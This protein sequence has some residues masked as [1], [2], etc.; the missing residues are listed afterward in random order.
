MKDQQNDIKRGLEHLPQ[1]EADAQV[2]DHIEEALNDERNP[3]L[4]LWC[5]AR[6]IAAM[7]AIVLAVQ[8][9]LSDD[10]DLAD[11][12]KE[13][14]RLAAE[15]S[16]G[17][18]PNLP[19]QPR[20]PVSTTRTTTTVSPDKQDTQNT[21]LMFANADSSIVTLNV[22]GLSSGCMSANENY[23]SYKWSMGDGSSPSLSNRAFSYSTSNEHTVTLNNSNSSSFG[24]TAGTDYDQSNTIGYNDMD[25]KSTF[26]YTN[27]VIGNS[28]DE[29][30]ISGVNHTAGKTSN[31]V[32]PFGR[33]REKEKYQCIILDSVQFTNNSSF[34]SQDPQ[35][36]EP[37]NTENYFPLVEND[38]LSPLKEPLST[39]GIDVD[40]ASYA[41]MRTKINAQQIVPK[42]AVRIEEFVNYFDYDYPQPV[43]ND[44]FS[45]NLETANCPWNAKHQLVRIGLKGKD[46]DYQNLKHSNLVFLIDVSGSMDSENKLP[47]VKKSLKLL[48]DQMGKEDRIA[49]V[50]YAGAAGLALEST[51]CSEKEYIKKKIDQ[52]DAGGS[53]AGGQGITLAYKIAVENR[54]PEGNNRVIMCTDG[55]FNV[56]QSTDSD[57]KN[58]IIENR[59]RGIFITACGFG[60]GNYQDSKME[61]IADN[62][63]GNYFYIDT[64]REST[65]VFERDI[66]ATLFTIAKDVKIQV[67]FNP[68]HVKAYRLI[69]YENRKMPP[70]DFNDDSK[71]GGELGAGHTV[72]ALY[73][74][75]PAG[76]DEAIP[77][78][79]G[80]KYQ[81]PGMNTNTAFTN[82]LLTVK[83]RYKKPNG[84]VSWLIEKSIMAGSKPFEQSS[85]DFRFAA[86]T[87]LFAQQLRQSRHINE[88]NFDLALKIL[89]QSK[90]SDINGDRQELITL[91]NQAQKLY[92]I[93]TKRD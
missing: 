13:E 48:V 91:V 6:S 36:Y 35:L 73:E 81:Q 85:T 31:I 76:S 60:M 77:G 93:Y 50:T 74:I 23:P 53:T 21:E 65:K 8:F 49:I 61:T 14:L 71:D 70:Q 27:G 10:Q 51:K 25:A 66:R 17:I 59:N 18:T 34:Y 82:E 79:L 37:V 90:G 63:N 32:P 7:L 16:V 87:A 4:I 15:Q 92:T 84:D 41:V 42:D 26:G 29:K 5:W 64:Y 72:T 22:N 44:P 47:L 9:W 19:T 39:F 88:E 69:G 1:Y 30:P 11:L 33:I 28:S 78:D 89:N 62:G 12:H 52:L 67:E 3:K 45:V 2:W 86:G 68:K 55:D 24:F 40:N 43:G 75:I 54:I 58:L 20:S 56:G 46:I 57:M 80:L 38:Y 83:L